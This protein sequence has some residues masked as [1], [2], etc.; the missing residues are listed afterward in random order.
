MFNG[1]LPTYYIRKLKYINYNI[2]LRNFQKKDKMV[3]NLIQKRLK[4]LH[5][6]IIKRPNGN[7]GFKT[8]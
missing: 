6:W 5:F 4:T 7:P 3:I 1:H 8:E 2:L